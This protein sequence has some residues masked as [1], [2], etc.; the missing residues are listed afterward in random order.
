MALEFTRSLSLSLL[1]LS[2]ALAVHLINP[3]TL[4]AISG[5]NMV[6]STNIR[7]NRMVGDGQVGN[8]GEY[9][10]EGHVKGVDPWYLLRRLQ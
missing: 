6:I 9:A 2:S 7:V 5:Y 1:H 4:V 3:K 8:K 10:G